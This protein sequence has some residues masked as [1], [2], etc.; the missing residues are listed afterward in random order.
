MLWQIQIKITSNRNFQSPSSLLVLYTKYDDNHKSGNQKVQ[1]TVHRALF[2][3]SHDS[4]RSWEGLGFHLCPFNI[5]FQNGMKTNV[6]V[7]ITINHDVYSN[8]G[9]G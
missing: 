4:I 1:V 5:T 6:L 8:A 7:K 3:V 9:G 2:D